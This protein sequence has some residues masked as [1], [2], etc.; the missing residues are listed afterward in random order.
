MTNQTSCAN[1]G[2]TFES[3][4]TTARYC[5]SACR[6]K[7]YRNAYI[8]RDI[9]K[10]SR[11]SPQE[12][13]QR[14][15]FL[16]DYAETHGPISVRG[17]YYQAEVANLPGID[18]AESSYTKIQRQVLKLR[19]VGRLGYEHIADATR[20]MRKPKSYD[21]IQDALAEVART[22]RRNLWRDADDYVEIWMEKD[23]LA[24]VVYPV[25]ELNDVPLM[26]T[27]GFSSETFAYNAVE[28]RGDDWRDYHVYALFDFDRS[29]Q[30]AANAL[31]KKL[32][33]F[34]KGRPFNVVFHNLAL[35]EQQIKEYGLSTRAPKR[36]T[37]ADRRWS[38]DFACELDALPPDVLR[39]IV[40]DAIERHLPR[41]HFHTAKASEQ[42]ERKWGRTWIDELGDRDPDP[43][44]GD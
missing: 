2:K 34:A 7:S 18:K 15:K 11:A 30:D 25:T 44:F 40:Q 27:R 39:T 13:E 12:M 19:R 22:Y 3:T 1:C 21:T 4:R 8:S 24:G 20:W 38:Y 32:M 5:S 43:L 10:R 31:E 14:A 16:I 37:A 23:A 33:R 35:T 41:A 28:A 9:R 29:G 42:I 36:K 26:V 17:L 6:Q